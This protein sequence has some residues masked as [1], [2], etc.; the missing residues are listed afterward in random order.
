[1]LPDESSATVLWMKDDGSSHLGFQKG[2]RVRCSVGMGGK[3][4]GSASYILDENGKVEF[5]APAP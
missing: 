2:Q 3:D 5:Q 1:M 4:A